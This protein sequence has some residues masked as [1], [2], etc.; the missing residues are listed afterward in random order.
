MIYFIINMENIEQ[1]EKKAIEAAINNQWDKAIKINKKI[2]KSDKNNLDA[3]LRLGFAYFQNNDWEN[4]EKIYKKVLK[5]QKVNSVAQ[6]FLEKIKILKEKK[7][8]RYQ[9]TN[10][11]IDPNLF[12][13]VPGRTTAVE[14]INLGQKN[15][16]AQLNIG[17][18]MIFKIR[19]RKV[20]VRTEKNQY[21]GSIPDDLSHRLILFT[22]AKSEYSCYIKEITL[23]KVVV[24]IKEDKK[25]NRVKNFVS[26]PKNLQSNI[27]SLRDLENEENLEPE[28]EIEIENE[29]EE[30]AETL[31]EQKDYFS[32]DLPV[33]EEENEEE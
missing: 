8:P 17:Q 24:F 32:F 23:K 9:K 10:L 26:F 13:E 33:D 25:G 27:Q 12:L 14:L 28:D 22:K 7:I 19:R 2:L 30:L 6:E 4:A 11:I 3:L 16:L 15:I 18:K 31:D 20:E 1:L 21:V 29:I 5:L